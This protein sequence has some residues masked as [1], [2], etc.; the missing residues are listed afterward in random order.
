MGDLLIMSEKERKRKVIMEAVL[1]GQFTLSDAADHMEVSYRQAKRIKHKYIKYG[2]A[3]LMHQSRGKPSGHRKSEK[4]KRKVIDLYQEKYCTWGPKFASEFMAEEDSIEVNPE[5]LRLWLK[6]EGLWVRKRKRSSF[7][8]RRERKEKFGELLQID[9]SI[10]NWLGPEKPKCCLFNMVD[11]A[12]STC[13]AMLDKGETTWGLLTILK[14][15]IKKYGIPQAVYVDLKSVYVSPSDTGQSVFEEVCKKLDIRIVRAYSPQAKGRVERS[16]QIFQDR[17]VKELEL[18]NI[19]ELDEA[20]KLLDKKVIKRFNDKFSKPASSQID[21]HR[22]ANSFGNLNHLIC[23]E[24]IRRVK[25]D[26]TV[27]FDNQHYQLD[28]YNN[29]VVTPKSKVIIRKHLNGRVSIWYKGARLKY[30][31]IENR[32]QTKPELQKRKLPPNRSKIGQKNSRKSPWRMRPQDQVTHFLKGG[33][34][35]END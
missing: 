8:Q 32:Q 22:K 25:N 4:F 34:Y 9:G 30:R 5:T 17:F 2:D 18:K 14:K 3:G 16:H 23:W 13:L 1:S 11:D 28:R 27:Q 31:S 21:G 35:F 19:T 29:I 33:Y 12:T 26:Y 6:A 24:E 10:H 15:W 20:N 7:R